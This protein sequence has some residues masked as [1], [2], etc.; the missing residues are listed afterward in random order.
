MTNPISIIQ[1]LYQA[2]GRGDVPAILELFHPDVDWEH[3]SLDH[4]IPWLR[5]GKGR[6]H[7]AGFFAEVAKLKF[8]VF[9]PEAFLSDGARQVAVFVRHDVTNTA[10]GKRFAGVEIHYWTLDEQG[11]I[12]RMKHFVDTAQH[13]AATRP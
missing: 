8:H 7:A 2:F 6:A 13:L 10:T 3:D 1:G 12:T 4:G 11:R 9:A 5:P